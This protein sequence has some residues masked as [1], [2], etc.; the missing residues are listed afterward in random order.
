MRYLFQIGLF[1]T[2]GTSASFGTIGKQPIGSSIR[3]IAVPR[4]KQLVLLAGSGA[5]N[6][7]R[8]DIYWE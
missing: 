1:H 2:S 3:K 6:F 5:Y 4:H 7:C 8:R